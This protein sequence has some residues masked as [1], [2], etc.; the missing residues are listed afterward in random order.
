MTVTARSYM[1]VISDLLKNT[2]R[3]SCSSLLSGKTDT[4]KVSGCVIK[5]EFNPRSIQYQY[6]DFTMKKISNIKHYC[7]V[8][9]GN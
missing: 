2:V 7:C 6:I 9:T 8:K 4:K 5:F 3:Y 1:Y